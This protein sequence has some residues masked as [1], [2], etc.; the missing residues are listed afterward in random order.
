M[1]LFDSSDETDG[2]FMYFSLDLAYDIC[3]EFDGEHGTWFS[4]HMVVG[5]GWSCFIRCDFSCINSPVFIV[6]CS[7]IAPSRGLCPTMVIVSPYCRMF[8]LS[9]RTC[10]CCPLLLQDFSLT[11]TRPLGRMEG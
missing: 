10:Q 1:F 5:S 6:S 7:S 8:G 9:Y 2:L 11:H 3:L 4:R